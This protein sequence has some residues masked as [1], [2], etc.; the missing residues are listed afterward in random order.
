MKI[1][2]ENLKPR[3]FAEL[4]NWNNISVYGDKWKTLRG[5]NH[6]IYRIIKQIILIMATIKR[7][8]LSPTMHPEWNKDDMDTLSRS[9]YNF[10]MMRVSN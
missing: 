3:Y 9:K 6:I 7:G 4:K 2:I 5:I 8:C 10:Q 1:V